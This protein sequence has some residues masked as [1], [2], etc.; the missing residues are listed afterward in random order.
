LAVPLEIRFR[1]AGA[2]TTVILLEAPVSEF[3]EAK[4]ALQNPERMLHLGSD[5]VPWSFSVPGFFVHMVLE[6]CATTG[7]KC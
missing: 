4:D 5:V 7:D 6:P 1:T 2:Q 3:V